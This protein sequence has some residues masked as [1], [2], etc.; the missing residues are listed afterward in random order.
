MSGV[1]GYAS[2]FELHLLLV[3]D[4][5]PVTIVLLIPTRREPCDQPCFRSK[6]FV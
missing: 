2:L 3:G 6:P 5:Q 1:V 4:N